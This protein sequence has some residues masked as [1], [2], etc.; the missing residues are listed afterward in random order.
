[1]PF[2]EPMHSQQNRPCL[3]RPLF[4]DLVAAGKA[5]AQSPEA[6]ISYRRRSHKMEA[7]FADASNNHGFKRARWRGLWKVQIQNWL[8]AVVH[9]LRMMKKGQRFGNE[10]VVSLRTTPVCSGLLPGRLLR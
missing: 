2:E 6:W 9:N 1:M 10:S 3:S 7:S 4:F 5:Q 8:I